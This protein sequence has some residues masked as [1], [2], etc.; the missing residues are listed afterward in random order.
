MAS[1]PITLADWGSRFKSRRSASKTKDKN[2]VRK[3]KIAAASGAPSAPGPLR[4]E[5][6]MLGAYSPRALDPKPAAPP[7]HP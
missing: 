6:A 2:C 7:R 5:F 1:R 3:I 4:P